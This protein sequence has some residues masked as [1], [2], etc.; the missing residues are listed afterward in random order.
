[1]GS[2]VAEPM[3]KI[4]SILELWARPD[5]WGE[6]PYRGGGLIVFSTLSGNYRKG[7]MSACLSTVAQSGGISLPFSHKHCSTFIF[8]QTN[9]SWEKYTDRWH[10]PVR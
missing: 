4:L 10:V 5:L 1:M 3:R 8:V 2:V 9:T 7:A 6:S